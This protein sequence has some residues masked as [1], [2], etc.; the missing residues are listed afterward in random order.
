MGKYLFDL[1]YLDGFNCITMLFKKN[2]LMNGRMIE[3]INS[4]HQ[5]QLMNFLHCSTENM[6]FIFVHSNRLESPG[7]AARKYAW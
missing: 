2:G 1:I 7:I 5:I 3:C 6:D 4:R